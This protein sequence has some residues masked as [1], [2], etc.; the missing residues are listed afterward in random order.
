MIPI[1]GLQ[2]HH[3]GVACRNLD[4]EARPYHLLGYAQAGED[5]VDPIQGITGRFLEGPGPRL[6][7]V[8]PTGDAEGVLSGM[9][10][11]GTKMYHLAFLARSFDEALNEALKARGKLVGSPV[12]AVAFGGRRIC[13]LFLPNLMLVELIEE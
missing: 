5:F 13:F 9:L 4:V 10:E 12:P 2:F 7:L 6:E 3:I 1:A 11:R 8:T